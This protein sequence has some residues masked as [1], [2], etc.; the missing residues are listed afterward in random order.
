[1]LDDIF[2][3]LNNHECKKSDQGNYWT[4]I[5]FPAFEMIQY[6]ESLRTT[7]EQR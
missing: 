5:P 6:F 1:V 2:K 7:K 3:W 4:P